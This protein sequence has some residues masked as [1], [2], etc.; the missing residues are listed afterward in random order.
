[1]SLNCPDESHLGLLPTHPL[2][3]ALEV[4]LSSGQGTYFW[5]IVVVLFLNGS[6]LCFIILVYLSLLMDLVGI[7]PPAQV[8]WYL[9]PASGV[10][11][12]PM[13]MLVTFGSRFILFQGAVLLLL[14]PDWHPFFFPAVTNTYLPL[15]PVW[16]WHHLKIREKTVSITGWP[17]THLY[18][19]YWKQVSIYSLWTQ[20]NTSMS[21]CTPTKSLLCH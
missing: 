5:C 2:P 20:T 11:A 6:E 7:T 1:M 8:V 10:T 16:G 14:L 3:T 17:E 21:Y 18:L 4:Y 15:L 19:L 13:L 12:L 9:T